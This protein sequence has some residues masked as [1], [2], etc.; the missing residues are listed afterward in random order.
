MFW[1]DRLGERGGKGH[2]LDAEAGSDGFDLVAEQPRQTLHVAHG[3]RRSDPDRLD[4]VVDPV[5]QQIETPCAEAFGFERLAELDD[6]LPRIAG[7]GFGG[8][9]R[10]GEAAANLDEIGRAYRID[11]LGDPPQGLIETPPSSGPKRSVKGARG[12]A[13]SSPMRSKPRT[14]R[15]S[16]IS[17]GRR[18]A[19]MGKSRIAVAVL[20]GAMT[21]D[22]RAR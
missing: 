8:A 15:L 12:F 3:L 21:I 17:L 16:T 14:R 20:P 7:D 9:D 4:T 22:G 5:K 1:R 11:R 13:A 19:A 18:R 10:L 6:K 2:D